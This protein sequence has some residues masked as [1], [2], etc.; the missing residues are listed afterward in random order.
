[1]NR[2]RPAECLT[3][4]ALLTEWQDKGF[5]DIPRNISWTTLEDWVFDLQ[6]SKDL[7]C[8]HFGVASLDGFGCRGMDA[9]VCAAGAVLH[10]SQN[11]LR[12]DASHITTLSCY[13]TDDCMIVD[14]ISQRNLELVEPIFADGKGNTL[15]SVLDET[16]T[17]M[18]TRLLREWILR[19]LRSKAAIDERLNDNAY[20]P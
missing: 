13:Q 19:P 6:V 7:L 14:R 11:N 17:P 18:G 5:P 10:Y 15:M 3:T 9:A 4:N 20:M 1:M 2:I 12:R 16:V 8:R